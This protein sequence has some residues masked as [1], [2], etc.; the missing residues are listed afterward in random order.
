[1]L[2]EVIGCDE[3][4]DMGLKAF[5]AIVVEDLHRG[6]LDGSV[7]SLSLA[8]CPGVIGLSEP[9]LD[10]V[11]DAHSIEDVRAKEAAAGSF[12]VLG[13]IGEGHAVVCE[14]DVY[15]VG[16]HTLLRK[17]EPSIFPDAVVELDIGE[18][19][20]PI[21]GQLA[22]GVAQLA[23]VNVDIAD[24][25]GLKPLALS[26]ATTT[27]PHRAMPWPA[28]TASMVCFLR[29]SS[30]QSGILVCACLGYIWHLERH[31]NWAPL[32]HWRASQNETEDIRKN[33]RRPGQL[34]AE[35]L[36]GRVARSQPA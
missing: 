17:A 4:Q 29:G 15:L 20:H 33:P 32:D 30:A 9:M 21:D 10:A 3:G 18:L 6:Y 12:A 25:V 31:P 14:H 7:H 13:Q 35:S 8:I 26:S 5:Q 23:A 27:S 22:I 11:F 1:M 36:V 24:F 16:F 34:I 28:R 2:C 19:G